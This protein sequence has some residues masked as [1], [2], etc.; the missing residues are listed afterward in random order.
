MNTKRFRKAL[1]VILSLLMVIAVLPMTVWAE[2]EATDVSDWDE[3]KA[4]LKADG[5]VKLANDIVAAEGSAAL[6]V[7][8]SA[9]VTLDLNGFKIDRAMDASE[10]QGNVIIVNGDLTV[11]DTS[12]DGAGRIT[13]GWTDGTGGGVWVR[14][15]AVFTLAGGTID[16]NTA[17]NLGGGVYLSGSRSN[18]IMTGGA[19]TG[20]TAKNGG[21]V[22][23]DST[24]FVEISGGTISG[25]T[26]RINGGGAWIGKNTTL[27]F[28]GGT[29]TGNNAQ[30]GGGVYVNNGNFEFIGGAISGNTQ[31]HGIDIG[32]KGGTYRPS[33]DVNVSCGDGGTVTA[34]KSPADMDE[35]VTLTVTPERDFKLKNLTVTAGDDVIPTEKLS[36]D[37]YTFIMPCSPVTVSAEFGELHGI[38]TGVT[39]YNDPY[40]Y[41]D[42]GCTMTAD[43]EY[44][45]EGETVT[46]TLSMAP[47]YVYLLSDVNYDIPVTQVSDTTLTFTMPDSDAD[48]Y[49][50][51]QKAQYTVLLGGTASSY[52][53]FLLNDEPRENAPFP[54]EYGDSVTVIFH[55]FDQLIKAMTYTYTENGRTVTA[56]IYYD[57]GYMGTLEGSFRMPNGDVTVRVEYDDVYNVAEDWD[58]TENGLISADVTKAAA[59]SVVTVA[60]A[61]DERY[62]FSEWNFAPAVELLTDETLAN[63]TRLATFEMPGSDV[64][65]SASFDRAIFDVTADLPDGH[66]T[67]AGEDWGRAGGNYSFTVTPD[68]GYMVKAVSAL[69]DGEELEYTNDGGVYTFT[70]PAADVTLSALFRVEPTWA[71]LV[72][73]LKSGGEIA[74]DCDYTA[75]AF[76]ETLAVP[77]DVSVS[78]DLNGHTINGDALTDEDVLIVNGELT[79]ADSVGTGRITGKNGDDVVFVNEGSF[80]LSGGRVEGVD[81][82]YGTA[83]VND[84]G[85]FRISG[86][87]V[88]G[89]GFADVIYNF[90]ELIM[91]DGVISGS[92]C[93]TAVFNRS[94]FRLNGGTVCGDVVDVVY[95][96]DTM[97][98]TGGSITGLVGDE[99]EYG[100]GIDLE[101]SVLFIS[102][103][104]NID[105]TE[106]QFESDADHGNDLNDFDILID[107]GSMLYVTGPLDPEGPQIG[108]TM[109]EEGTF[110]EGAA[111]EPGESVY[112]LTGSDS[113][114]FGSKHPE[115]GVRLAGDNKLELSLFY[116]VTVADGI[117]GGTVAASAEAAMAGETVS[118]T[119][120]PEAGYAVGSVSVNGTP[121]EPAD[122]EYGFEMPARDVTVSAVFE[123]YADTDQA[124]A[125]EVIAKIDAIGKVEYTDASKA[126]IDAART[127]L[128]ALTGAQKELVPNYSVLESAEDRYAELK[129]AAERQEPQTDPDKPQGDGLCKWC[130]EPHSGFWGKIVGFF[131]SILYFYA[132]LFGA[133]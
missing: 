41:T 117:A 56:D 60:A 34:D 45:I 68:E 44:A 74:L 18:F 67:I 43:K 14:M 113:G 89:T 62:A 17:S 5:E 93:N 25:N 4:A 123:P 109:I 63:G 114:R 26:A 42:H 118:L 50:Y 15:G 1:A 54:A 22:G 129:A 115:Y 87:E 132:H 6:T 76:D 38:Y 35:T 121:I 20:N 36:D 46:L 97:I 122:G 24:G 70:M 126:K 64:R 108:V 106:K 47:G 120:T 81:N 28:S 90:G 107:L 23:M 124:A 80:T 119:V 116:T 7:S 13:G 91:D 16:G 101:R 12:S 131:H 65:F 11:I 92:G 78:L 40:G 75:S 85:T 55:P 9:R 95:S 88:L 3:L 27:T 133:R 66:G 105:V 86:G 51:V 30:R 102:G 112:T 79:V 100:Y 39:L 84:G 128:D 98:M 82:Y 94:S 71:D 8:K 72:E 61:P 37:T 49:A 52:V 53:S 57:E 73:A 96:D 130:G 33:F 29:I 103:P 104:V 69:A 21:G 58:N 99:Y 111:S 31:T 110:A 48:A 32:S 77:E 127:A 2:P 125:D 59:G 83:F 19:I 10:K